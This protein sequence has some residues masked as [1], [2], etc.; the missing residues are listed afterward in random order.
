MYV[1]YITVTKISYKDFQGNKQETFFASLFQKLSARRT[2]NILC[3][4]FSRVS[5]IYESR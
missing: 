1:K 3:L 4:I 5:L 2:K